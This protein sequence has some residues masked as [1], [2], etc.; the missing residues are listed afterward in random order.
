[1]AEMHLS[2]LVSHG[3]Q[4]RVEF[5]Q[6]MAFLLYDFGLFHHKEIGRVNALTTLGQDII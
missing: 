6:R 4:M 2:V 5:A 3:L 1:M